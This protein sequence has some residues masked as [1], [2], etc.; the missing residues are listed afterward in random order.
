ME[1]F[2]TISEK[3]KECSRFVSG[4]LKRA[5]RQSRSVSFL[6]IVDQLSGL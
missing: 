4:T 5:V 6:K 1:T 3:E 2:G